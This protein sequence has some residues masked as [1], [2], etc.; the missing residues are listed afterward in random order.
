MSRETRLERA[1]KIVN[2]TYDLRFHDFIM[3]QAR[4]RLVGKEF[5]KKRP[6]TGF[7]S[8]AG[9]GFFTIR[10]LLES[11]FDG[12]HLTG[13]IEIKIEVQY[14][15][16]KQGEPDT[17]RVRM[18]YILKADS[19]AKS[20]RW[21]RD[22]KL[23]A[24][25]VGAVRESIQL[26]ASD[27]FRYIMTTRSHG[28]FVC[29]RQLTDEYSMAIGV[30]PECVKT[31]GLIFNEVEPGKKPEDLVEQMKEL[32]KEIQKAHPDK[33]GCADMF[34]GLKKQLDELRAIAKGQ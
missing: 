18:V 23:T 1:L 16:T 6:S 10:P 33:G 19:T 15:G 4:A 5:N 17:K 31:I 9:G 20:R 27:P 14:E 7:T 28:C 11:S 22:M 3:G 29:G 30:G 32:R 26:L 24:A 25:L 34:I 8:T 2:F 12:W 13:E 21:Y